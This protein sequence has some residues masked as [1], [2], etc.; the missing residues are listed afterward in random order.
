MAIAQK[1]DT[2][3]EQSS[4]IRRMFEE[5]LKLR[6]EF[7][8]GAVYDFSLGNPN[9]APPGEFVTL[10][11]K[12]AADEQAGV[13]AYMP[14]AGFEETRS[15]VATHLT[16][17][18]GIQV[19]PEQVVMTCGAAGG[20][21][22]IF[23]TLLD[24]GDEVIIPT[25]CF[26]EYR[27]YVDNAGGVPRFVPTRPDFSL[28]LEAIEAVITPRTKVIL[29]NSPNNPTGKI[30]DDATI[31]ELAVLMERKSSDLDRD[32]Y[33][34]SDEPYRDIVYDGLTLPSILASY[35]N[36]ITAMSW[37]K[38]LS[39]PG[40][41]IGYLAVNPG[42]SDCEKVL[43]GLSLA[44]RILGFVNAPAF[45]QRVVARLQGVRVPVEEYQ[46]KR[47][48]LCDGLADRGFEVVKPEGAFYLFMKSPVEDDVEFVK[49]LQQKKILT[50]PGSGFAGPG[51]I[52]IA[53]CVDDD[54]ISKAMDGFG[55]V[56]DNIKSGA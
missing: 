53:Y 16:E 48:L 50:V 55:E 4:W 3:M 28:D 17:T 39:I 37:S 9:L 8:D 5:G 52:R 36:S 19:F 27:F 40:E 2:F 47:D 22:V 46:R 56:L 51:H 18:E 35:R 26:M 21:N 30:Y 38:S 33:L 49:A 15:A 32:I 20:L 42:A 41:R 44:T 43:N 31:E 54:T 11:K 13:H 14:N 6:K 29:V 24:P 10:M 7:G 25:P 45:M 34:V 12:T 23:K 1:M